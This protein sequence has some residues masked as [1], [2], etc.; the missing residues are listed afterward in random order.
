MASLQQLQDDTLSYLN[1]QD[2]VN[3]IPTWVLAVETELAQTLR[4]RCQVTSAYQNIDQAY[5]PLPSD[6]ATMESI[7]DATT[8]VELILKDAWSGNWFDPQQDDRNTSVIWYNPTP[9]ACTSYRIVA[10]CLEL[11]PHPVIPNPP[12][13][14]WV[15]QQILMAWYAKPRPLVLPSDTN[16]IL[17]QLYTVYLW[18]MIKQGAMFELDDDRV[19][20]ADAAWQ[21][22]I[23]RANLHTQQSTYS[24]APFVSEI[25]C[26][27]A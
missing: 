24:G 11:L 16:P 6:F 9:P 4:A 20:Q 25:A 3:R 26:N 13:P 15:P 19:A 22:A 12:D 8:G 17:E 2:V 14:T 21:Q 10:N 1:R 23:T 7:R 27:F 5:I 18:G